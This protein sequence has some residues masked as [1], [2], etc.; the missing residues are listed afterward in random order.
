MPCLCID[1]LLKR[2]DLAG[3][4]FAEPFHARRINAHTDMLH[5]CQ[6]LCQRELNL[7]EKRVHALLRDLC[8]K[9][10]GELRERGDFREVA[11]RFPVCNALAHA[12][13]FDRIFRHG[14]IQQIGAE[15]GVQ[16]EIVNRIARFH[17]HAV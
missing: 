14:G 11:K 10:V 16:R 7:S 12:E 15:L 3:K 4:H 5:L 17:A 2:S 13:L 9:A 1:L 6:H 8:R